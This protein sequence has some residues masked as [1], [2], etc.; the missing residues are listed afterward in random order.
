MGFN[1][2]L[3]LRYNSTMDR[4]VRGF[5][6]YPRV[7]PERV[8][9]SKPN[10]LVDHNKLTVWIQIRRPPRQESQYD[11]EPGTVYADQDDCVLPQMPGTR[12]HI[13]YTLN[14]MK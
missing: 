11:L 4:S 6:I 5:L 8:T 7:F 10:E 14:S 9:M 3:R 2:F 12:G 1:V 13:N